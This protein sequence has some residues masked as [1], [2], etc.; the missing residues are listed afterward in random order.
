[1][2]FVMFGCVYMWILKCVGVC[3]YGF[4]NVWVCV[5]GFCNVW[6]L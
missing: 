2:G 5:Y 4:C 3:M 1:M 6:V